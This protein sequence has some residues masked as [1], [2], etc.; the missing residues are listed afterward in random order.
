MTNSSLGDDMPGE[1][2]HIAHAASQNRDLQTT[3][4]IEMDVHRYYR[5]IVATVKRPGQPLG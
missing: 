5:Q 2:A 1:V 3:V 4:M